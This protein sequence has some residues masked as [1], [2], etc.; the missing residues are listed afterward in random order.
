MANFLHRREEKLSRLEQL[1][2]GPRAITHF[3]S[4]ETKLTIGHRAVLMG[5]PG[6][7]LATGFVIRAFRICRPDEVTDEEFG[8]APKI[9]NSVDKILARLSAW[10]ASND[11]IQVVRLEKQSG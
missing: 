2:A 7:I 1:K 6:E 11:R 8:H 5:K 9:A 4:P 3:C 10:N